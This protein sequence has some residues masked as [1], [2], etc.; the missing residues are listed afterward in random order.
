MNFLDEFLFIC[1]PLEL[2]FDVLLFKDVS[3][4]VRD[5]LWQEMEVFLYWLFNVAIS[6]VRSVA[7][8]FICLFVFCLETDLSSLYKM[9]QVFASR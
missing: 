6:D 8:V 2:L 5:K 1:S 3:S 7:K 4:E 9:E